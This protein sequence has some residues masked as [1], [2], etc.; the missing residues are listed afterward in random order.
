MNFWGH[1]APEASEQNVTIGHENTGVVVDMGSAVRGFKVGDKV[2]CLGC[3]YAC[4]ELPRYL[5]KQSR[6]TFMLMIK[7]ID[8]CEG[9][10]VHNLLCEAGTGKMHGFST[11]GH[12]AE[13]SVSDYR[14]AMVLPE[15]A[16]MISSAP[17]FCAGVTGT[18]KLASFPSFKR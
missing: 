5:Q 14:N 4:C 1:S 7:F 10:Q 17:L 15:D 13:Y 16:D 6:H 8:E 9:C 12:F 3:S 2:G 18:S 11:A